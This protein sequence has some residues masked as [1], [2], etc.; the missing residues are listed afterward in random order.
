M[1]KVNL[2]FMLLTGIFVILQ[3]QSVW[4]AACGYNNG[5][6]TYNQAISGSGTTWT[7]TT[8]TQTLS[9]V[10]NCQNRITN[11]EAKYKTSLFD[12]GN[13]IDLNQS[14]SYSGVKYYKLINTSDVYLDTYGYI[15]FSLESGTTHSGTITRSLADIKTGNGITYF[16]NAWN[17]NS[18]YESATQGITVK[19]LR[20]Y[21]TAAPTTTIAKN[22]TLGALDLSVSRNRNGNPLHNGR[23]NVDVNVNITPVSGKT[24]SLNSPSVTLPTVSTNS[25]TTTGNE[26]G[27]T[28]FPITTTCSGLANK[29]LYFTLLDNTT[30]ANSTTVLTNSNS[31]TNNVGIKIYD[32]ANNTAITYKSEYSFGTLT[33]SASNATST[34]NFYAKYYKRD[35][36]PVSAGT[37]NGQ[38][39]VLV[40]YK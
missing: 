24:C 11:N 17:H 37:V 20:F 23:K 39:T 13:N 30:P 5:T 19:D 36:N 6:G 18:N 26:V 22:I 29:Q 2:L 8:N 25:L 21:F 12:I 31:P 32:A 28:N 33:N 40:V 34:K 14:T 9:G 7:T 3:G 15:S 1:K 38:A 27:R 16:L 10:V 4:A 35:N